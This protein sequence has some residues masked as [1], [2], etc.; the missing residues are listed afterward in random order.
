VIISK[1]IPPSHRDELGGFFSV[2]SLDESGRPTSVRLIPQGRKKS[3]W[4][5]NYMGHYMIIRVKKEFDI[6]IIDLKT[7]KLS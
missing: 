5:I 3:E 4:M 6:R 2:A 1:K 7:L